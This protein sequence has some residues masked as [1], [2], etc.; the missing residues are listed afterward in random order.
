MIVDIY[1]DMAYLKGSEKIE[2]G[3]LDFFLYEDSNGTR[4]C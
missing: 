1:F 3:K 4:Y 2:K